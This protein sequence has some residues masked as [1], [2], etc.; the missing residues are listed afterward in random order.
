MSAQSSANEVVRVQLPDGSELS[1]PRG[2][3][4]SELARQLGPGLAKAAL[5]AR[6]DGRLRDLNT[7]LEEDCKVEIVTWKDPEGRDVYRHTSSHIMAQAVK[8]VIPEAKVTIGPAIEDGF[9]YD[10]DLPEPLTP[11]TLARIEEEMKK[12]VEEGHEIRRRELPREEAI[13]L[14]RQRGEPYKVEIIEDLPADQTISCYEQGEFVDL[15][16]GPHLPSTA[17][18][19]AFKL[20]NVAGAYWR[21]DSRNRMLQRIYG[22][23]F[24]DRKMLDEHLR[25]LEEARKRD[26]R[27]IGKEL[28]LFSFHEEGPGFPFFHPNGVVIFNEIVGFLRQEL[29]K[30]NY[31]EIMT[32][33]ILNEELW[34]RSGH[35]DHY[36]ENMY[37]TEIDERTYAVKPMNCPGGLLV[38]KTSLHS[39]RDLPLKIAEFG[40]VHRHELSGVLHGLFRVRSFTQDDAHIFTTPEQLE[41]AI[42]ETIEF[43]QHVY[44]VFGF[45]D[46]HME[47]S[48]RPEKS[49]G[50]DQMWDTATSALQN[51]LEKLGIDYK[52]NPGDGAF[53]GPKIDFHV[54]DCLRR[55]WQCGTIQVD[56]SMP[57]RFDI[58]YVGADGQKYR[59]VMVHR[60]I[61]GSLERFIGVLLEHTAGNL[62]VW[63]APVQAAVLPIS[64]KLNEYAGRVYESLRQA[65]VRATLDG[66]QE[67]IGAKIRNAELLKVP[68]M[69]IVGQ[70]EADAVAV[71]VRRH[72]K[73]D[74][75]SQP[76]DQ[77]I[78]EILREIAER[79]R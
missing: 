55:S 47:L 65:G 43:I 16:R 78:P 73:G 79:R 42:T 26:H 66:G 10:F 67:K 8:R 49:I 68:Y 74:L 53:Y 30:R 57:E 59:P 28:D 38:Y 24:P 5:A 40:R 45:E 9:Y 14:F 27:R 70:K 4:V 64:D 19:K 51:A 18:V 35:W 34:H 52:L 32:P 15:C 33:L 63:L 17:A 71:S 61:V 36:K 75:G 11:E 54:K 31:V 2:T 6:I 50:S 21:G 72:G 1:V 76:L 25:L 22:T 77:F 48:T 60:A 62:P 58:S 29:A 39:Y 23:S 12:I 37:F 7:P 69:L 56:F 46:Y 3:T 41:D 20:L 44:H 13:E